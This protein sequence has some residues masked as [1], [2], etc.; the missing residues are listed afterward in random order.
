MNQRSQKKQRFTSEEDQLIIQYVH[1]YGTKWIEIEKLM[2]GRKSHQIRERYLNYLD[3]NLTKHP[4]TPEEDNL[5]LSFTKNHI[6]SWKKLKSHFS[7]RTDV[8]LKNRFKYLQKPRKNNSKMQK[9]G[10]SLP[11]RN[12]HQFESFNEIEFDPL[13]L[14]G[15]FLELDENFISFLKSLSIPHEENLFLIK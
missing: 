4:W 3:D 13:I 11:E 10:K 15:T 14:G 8:H 12:Y 9:I 5:L 2:E 1:D 6:F 7:G